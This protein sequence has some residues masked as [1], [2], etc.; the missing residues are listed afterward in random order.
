M[1][2]EPP[3]QAGGRS[4]L[5]P[6]GRRAVGLAALLTLVTACALVPGGGSATAGSQPG[7]APLSGQSVMA[8]QLEAAT[9]P[10]DP[11]VRHGRLD[12]GLSY[13]LLQNGSPGG[14]LELSLV[15]GVGSLEQR[16]L[17]DGVAHFLEHMLFNG[18]EVFPGNELGRVLQRLGVELGPD[19]NAYTTCESTVYQLRV[20]TDDA[21]AVEVAFDVLDQWASAVTLEPTAV[22][23]ERGVVLDE[24]RSKES[25]EGIIT[26]HFDRVYTKGSVYA[27]CDPIGTREAIQT[28]GVPALRDFYD[29]WYRPDLMA[30]VAVGD[31]P[32]DLLEEMVVS[33]FADNQA[34][35]SHPVPVRRWA[36]P[37]TR[38]VVESITHQDVSS[39][40][41]SVDYS[42]PPRRRGTG[43]GEKAFLL[44]SFIADLLQ[45]HLD[46]QVGTG[47]LPIIRPYSTTFNHTSVHPF[48][49]FNFVAEDP[50]RA[51]EIFLSELRGL[52][53][54]GFRSV[55]VE[56]LRKDYVRHLDQQSVELATLQDHERVG[57]L[58]EHI[59]FGWSAE[60]PAARIER[61]QSI[62]S[63]F[64]A[65]VV[66]G[67]FAEVLEASAPLVIVV[68][69]DPTT[70]PTTGDLEAA[71]SRSREGEAVTPGEAFAESLS[72]LLA[73][74]WAPVRPEAVNEV[75][76]HGAV[77]W[78]FANGTRVLFAPSQIASGQVNLW[79]ESQGGHSLLAPGDSA[80][81]DAVTVAVD[82]SGV[83]AF[84]GVEVG[85]FEDTEGIFLTSYID[86]TTEGFMGWSR[87]DSLESLFSLLYMTIT[88]PRVDGP[89]LAEAVEY[90]HTLEQ[91]PQRDA[92]TAS[93]AAAWQ[94]RFGEAPH[95]QMVPTADQVAGFTAAA[96]LSMFEERLGK[97]D[98]LVVAVV[99][100][101]EVGTVE[102]LARRYV[103]TLAPGPP[104]RWVDHW[105]DPPLGVTS[106]TVN[107][108]VGSAEAGFDL[109]FIRPLVADEELRAAA[110]VLETVLRGRLSDGLR[111][112]MGLSYRPGDVAIQI[113]EEPDALVEVSV[114]VSGDPTRIDQLHE[115]TITEIDDLASNGPTRDEVYRAREAVLADL[116]FVT[117]RDLLERLI[118][119][120][121]SNGGDRATLAERYDQVVELTDPALS[122]AAAALLDPDHRIEV[123]RR[124]SG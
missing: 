108:G 65:D 86:H 68:G 25:V 2:P 102:D 14:N 56:R 122:E 22:E 110:L 107:A 69:N 71:V 16:A 30:V 24:Y 1:F 101:V 44:D 53:H 43:A 114:R 13:Y 58:I 6:P 96:A 92:D 10:L 64:T 118:A 20:K 39:P 89:A 59:L 21:D 62:I 38:I 83:A 37:L 19:L 51:L 32:V 97:V 17:G 26:D 82:G 87:A 45:E 55:V 120:G 67:R 46:A 113:R 76:P 41:V 119:W 15:V 66:N 31:Q 94:A 4:G 73:E 90:L 116:D 117:N 18:T 49:G 112:E 103:G 85:G 50:P 84:D 123:F 78:V 91:L 48:L 52:A 88:D 109:W 80:L 27:G 111:E 36:E 9:I 28:V 29:H 63:T 93:L 34:R 33:R 60:A 54:H 106:V 57:V 98:D 5:G 8:T 12:N 121:R 72:A 61:L 104:D 3:T 42:L 95:L 35:S 115:R 40:F 11:A 124:P 99:G 70:Q 100:D 7:P 81:V 79:A 105:P 47:R 74:P 75:R 77:E 23:A